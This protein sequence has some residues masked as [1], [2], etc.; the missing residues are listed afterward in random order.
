MV[1]ARADKRWAGVDLGVVSLEL[2]TVFLDTA[3]AVVVC[4]CLAKKKPMANVWMIILATCELYGG[5]YPPLPR[6]L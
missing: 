2:L 6:V 1:Y 5:M 4:Y 3:L